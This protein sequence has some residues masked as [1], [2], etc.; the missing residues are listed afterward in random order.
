MLYTDGLADARAPD[1]VLSELDLAG[2]LAEARDLNGHQLAEFLESRATGGADARDDIVIVV[3]E[4]VG[5]RAD[6]L[7]VHHY[8][9]R[10]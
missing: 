8:G 2:L 3:L 7:S 1:V 6:A 9:A 4:G 5:S 10:D